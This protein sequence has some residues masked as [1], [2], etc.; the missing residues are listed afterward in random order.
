VELRIHGK[1]LSAEGDA[2][3]VEHN[4]H[5]NAIFTIKHLH[6][7]VV[8]LQTH[9]GKFVGV[10]DHGNVYLSYHHH[11]YDTKFHFE[12]HGGNNVAFRAKSGR[13]LGVH[14]IGHKI[15]GVH[16]RGSNEIFQEIQV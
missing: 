15:H 10:A 8:E 3:Y 13:Y 14:M 1:W 4:A 11:D 6:D 7:D 12:H 9:H 5:N 2:L 16:E